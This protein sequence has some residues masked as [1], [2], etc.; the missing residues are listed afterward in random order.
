MLHR[1]TVSFKISNCFLSNSDIDFPST[2]DWVEVEDTYALSA[3]NTLQEAV[4][5]ILKFLGLASANMTENVAEG[6]HTHTLLCSGTFRGG[7][8]ILVRSKL[9][10]SD[11]VTMQLTVRSTHEEVAELV[12]SAIG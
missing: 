4:N 3:V 6:V 10:L 1:L 9:A 8:D 12:T 7:H 2:I 5:T 11:G